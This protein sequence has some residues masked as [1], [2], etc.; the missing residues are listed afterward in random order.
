MHPEVIGRAYRF[1]A[2]EAL[3]E[4]IVADG[5]V[6]LARLDQVADHVEPLLAAASR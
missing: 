4:S 6:W 3:V 5:D 1:A 2:L